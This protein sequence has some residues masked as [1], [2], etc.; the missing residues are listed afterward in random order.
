LTGDRLASEITRLLDAPNE[1][2]AM[3][4]S[5]RALRR[6]DAAKTTVDLIEEMISRK[7]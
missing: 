6:G 2:N 1:L 5:S 4:E 3:E 7:S